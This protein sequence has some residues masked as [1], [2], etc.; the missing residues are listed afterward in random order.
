MFEHI[1]N[2]LDPEMIVVGSLL[3]GLL[4]L[5][6]GTRPEICF[7]LGFP[8]YL[9]L[10]QLKTYFSVSNSAGAALFPLAAVVACFFRGRRFHF[11]YCEKLIIGLV[12]LMVFSICYSPSPTYGRDKAALFCFMVVPV[13]V[14][15]PNIITS[16]KSLRSVVSII[17]LTLVI[18]VFTSLFLRW[19][20]GSVMG[21]VAGLLSVTLASQFL[22]LAAVISYLYII[23][24]RPRDARKV[25]FIFVLPISVILLFMTGTRAAVLAIIITLL[26]IYWFVHIDWFERIFKK[27][28]KTY[29]MISLGIIIVLTVPFILKK[30]LPEIIYSRF[31]SIESFFSNF[32]A[33][34]IR[35]W[36]TSN[37]R[38]LNYAS[39]VKSFFAHPL[40]GVGAG[41]YK[42]VL[43]DFGS[44]Q[45]SGAA[46]DNLAPAYSHNV[47]LEFATEQGILGLIAFL[48]V[49]YL[50]FRMILRLRNVYHSNPQNPFLICCCISLYVFGLCVAMTA[51]DIPKMMI[52]WWGMGLLLTIDRIYRQPPLIFSKSHGLS[53][54]KYSFSK[55]I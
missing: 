44:S 21:R 25:I 8:A 9:F 31:S 37:T 54:N 23:L 12:L 42:T 27:P 29:A 4:V 35:H 17:V 22:G 5:L 32:T 19:Q 33:Y 47:V 53:S 3:F 28:H 46:F 11:E 2:K 39:A 40:T 7:A 6:A 50:N 41:G 48:C 49:L 15:A 18:F 10:G 30:V 34:E 45:F 36:Q 38:V 24:I 26:L 14:F 13:I 1:F 52:L 55:E 20:M 43:A 16:V 51:S